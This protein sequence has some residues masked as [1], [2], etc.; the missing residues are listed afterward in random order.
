MNGEEGLVWIERRVLH[1]VLVQPS[2]LPDVDLQPTHF[3]HETHG[4]LFEFIVRENQNATADFINVAEAADRM[5]RSHIGVLAAE[6][7]CDRNL[8][9]S[10]HLREDAAKISAAWRAREAMGI[11]AVLREEAGRRDSEAVDRAIAA[12]MALHVPE[13]DCEQTAQSAMRA[14]WDQVLAAKD[15]GGRVLGVSTGLSD[16][17]GALGGLHNSD[18]IVV[19]ARPAMGKTGLLLGMT[20]A[21]ARSVGPVGLISGEQPHEQVGMRWMAAGSHVSLGKLRAGKL[22]EQR[23]WDNASRAVQEFGSLPI[24]ILDRSAP[25]IAEVVRVARRWKHQF[26]IRALYVDYL[27]RIEIASRAK[28]PKHERVGEI[29]RA[30]KNLARDLQIPVVAL[31]QVSRDAEDATRPQMRHLADSSE[32]EKEADQIMMLWRDLSDPKANTAPAEIN[33]VKNRHGNIGTVHCI[34]HGGSTSFLDKASDHDER[35]AA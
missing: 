26:G 20:A 9:Q 22:Y 28:A 4:E 23:E 11:A 5:G 32:I 18:L 13:R 3:A 33:V 25:D 10:T 30:L 31:A 16:L 6:I 8:W 24:R 34:W 2:R 19:G 27:Q 7:A 12:L 15:A 35:L 14:A 17:D 21:G 29:T 1:T